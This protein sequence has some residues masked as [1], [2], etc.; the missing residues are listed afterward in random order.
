MS[1]VRWI[2]FFLLT[3][4]FQNNFAAFS[5]D[6]VIGTS[7]A[8]APVAEAVV[9]PDPM[10]LDPNW[11]QYYGVSTTDLEKRVKDTEQ[12]YQRLS[13]KAPAENKQE[14]ENYMQR[15]VINL[16]ALPSALAQTVPSFL[17]SPLRDK[18][19][20]EEIL[21]MASKR[22]ALESQL[23]EEKKE[24]SQMKTRASNVRQH[25]DALYVSYMGMSE[26]TVSKEIAGLEII[27]LRMALAIT[28]ESIRLSTERNE[29]LQKEIDFLQS[30]LLLAFQKL[31]VTDIDERALKNDIDRSKDEL[32]RLQ[33]VALV[34]EM[35]A[36]GT[37]G[38]SPLERAKSFFF[39]QKAVLD[40]ASE[41]LAK[42]NVIFFEA[43]NNLLL[44]SQNGINEDIAVLNR[45]IFDWQEELSDLHGVLTD[46]ESKTTQE[47]ERSL[48]PIEDTKDVAFQ[49]V[50]DQRVKTVV[51]TQKVLNDLKLKI[52]FDNLMIANL[53]DRYAVE[54][55]S[56]TVWFYGA[57]D[58]F[59]SCCNPIVGWL[60]APLV[61]I[62]GVPITV[63]SLLKIFSLIA[64]TFLTSSLARRLI[65]RMNGDQ[66]HMTD[67]SLFIIDK[68]IHYFILC[69]GFA[70]TLASVGLSLS[71]LAIVLGALSV[72]IGFGLQTIVNN[73]L[74]SLIIMFSRTMKVGDIIEF[75]DGKSGTVTAINIQNTII[76]SKDGVD[77]IIPNSKI[78][79]ERLVNWTLN[80]NFRRLHIPFKV[81]YGTDKELVA[82]AACEAAVKVPCTVKNST[83]LSDPQ[84]WLVKLGDAGLEFELIVWVNVY[85][86]GH[87]GSMNASYLWELEE[88][89]RKY[90]IEIPVPPPPNPPIVE[91]QPATYM[92]AN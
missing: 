60:Y 31:E 56:S 64:L 89:F 76:H 72:G 32:K 8:K 90:N 40:H 4:F 69:L 27:S 29:Q 66:L 75:A 48:K 54:E 74:S 83:H 44:M 5:L 34:S 10:N 73:F 58:W 45:E 55:G 9:P 37:Y 70:I 80:D 26:P 7:D 77:I 42:A 82:K 43:K 65:K 84:V 78:L 46:W 88:A 67:S 16:K 2:L 61:K 11:W 41:A 21:G 35:N 62:G 23:S 14:I 24:L 13:E 59:E 57:W 71:N 39:N 3:C 22:K 53:K 38:D 6:D 86:F 85:G 63:M 52:M 12:F 19:S 87:R 51:E 68:V 49:S 91:K 79:G 25:I 47:Y 28:D 20:F 1:N 92:N 36:L 17:A 18:Y 33:A 30:G 50:Q 15:I 81:A